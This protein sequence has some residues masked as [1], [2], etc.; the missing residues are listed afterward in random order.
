MHYDRR[1]GEESVPLDSELSV[2]LDSELSVPL[3]SELDLGFRVQGSGFPF[4]LGVYR[5]SRGR[6]ES[7]YP[8]RVRG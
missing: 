5:D 8:E 2:P 7:V 6:G 3:D 4:P 1:R